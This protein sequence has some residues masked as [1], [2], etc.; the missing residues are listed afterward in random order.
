MVP[1]LCSIG[2]SFL[3]VLMLR[4]LTPFGARTAYR[5][6]ENDCLNVRH[7]FGAGA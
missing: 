6:A 7:S 1:G 4:S 2:R 3:T 5:H